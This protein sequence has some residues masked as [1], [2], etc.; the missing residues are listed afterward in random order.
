MIKKMTGN[1]DPY[2]K[3]KNK[4]NL[5]ALDVLPKVMKNIHKSQDRL[6]TA[7]E[8]CIAA[9]IID[10]GVKN[11]LNIQEELDKIIN[12]EELIMKNNHPDFFDFYRFKKYALKA[13]KIML[14]GDN[15]G[16]IAF[17]NF[18]MEE[19]KLLNPKVKFFYA[20]RK[21]AIINDAL[22][23]DALFCGIDKNAQ[24]IS[25][26][27]TMPGTVLEKCSPS[28]LKYYKNM[29]LI[30]SK[31]QGNFESFRDLNKPVFY[32]FMAKCPLVAKEADCETGMINLKFNGAM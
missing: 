9:N 18:L 5:L 32:F 29:D 21:A 23:D 13:E 1:K 6:L 2:T 3:I 15:A 11:T 25:T 7:V 12:Q 28:F 20:V 8:F 24:I 31:G 16:E 26:G 22:K 10:F 4:S 14:L 27:V 17:D 19:L 30:I